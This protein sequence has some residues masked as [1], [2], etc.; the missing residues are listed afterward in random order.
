MQ[1]STRIFTISENL[2]PFARDTVHSERPSGALLATEVR[3]PFA[4]APSAFVGASRVARARQA[5]PLLLVIAWHAMRL[6]RTS[7][8]LATQRYARL[9]P[10][11]QAF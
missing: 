6:P 10:T 1:K 8:T 5:Q 11:G 9:A 3:T 7:A 4:V 2:R